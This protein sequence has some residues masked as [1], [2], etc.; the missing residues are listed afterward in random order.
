VVSSVPTDEDDLPPWEL[1]PEPQE[2]EIDIIAFRE[3]DEGKKLV[4]FLKKQYSACKTARERD[5]R[6]W[7]YNLAMYNG[8]QYLEY[9][10]R[11][12]FRGNLTQKPKPSNKERNTINRLESIIRTEMA[13]M[14]SQKPSASVLPA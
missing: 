8:K 11:G 1:T 6:Q 12:E 10:Q 4:S 5:E 9:I 2:P 7:K 3:S 14:T 13:R